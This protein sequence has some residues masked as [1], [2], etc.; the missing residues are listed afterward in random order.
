MTTSSYT[1]SFQEQT[2][3][4]FFGQFLI[5]FNAKIIK[6]IKLSFNLSLP[7]T[8]L[9]EERQP[10]LTNT[11]QAGKHGKWKRSDCSVA[12]GGYSFTFR[13]GNT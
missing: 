2:L 13:N 4:F 9:H 3:I 5:V 11:L 6:L 8:V 10:V 1:L 12:S 7:C